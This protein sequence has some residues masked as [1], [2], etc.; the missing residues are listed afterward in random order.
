[1]NDHN[2]SLAGRLFRFVESKNKLPDALFKLTQMADA[3]QDSVLER[4]YALAFAGAATD[5]V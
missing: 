3:R 5:S 2:D 1:V 4:K